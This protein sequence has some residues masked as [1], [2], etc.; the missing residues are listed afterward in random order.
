MCLGKTGHFVVMMV[1]VILGFC[2][3]SRTS[4]SCMVKPEARVDTEAS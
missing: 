4:A 3:G 2:P 1:K